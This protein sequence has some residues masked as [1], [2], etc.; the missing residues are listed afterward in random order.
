MKSAPKV[1][2]NFMQRLPPEILTKILLY[3]D[4][5]SL[6]CIGHVNKLFNLLANNNAMW[7]R[8][9]MLAF[10]KSKKWKPKNKD[11]TLKKLST[12]EIQDKPEGYWR[13]LYFRTMAGYNENKW[14]KELQAI[15][16]YTGLPN[17]T[18]W[19]LRNLH[20]TWELTVTDKLGSQGTFEQRN[21]Y[22]SES[23]V[24]VCWS[25]G[26]WPT[27]HQLS[28]LQL[29][30]VMR[31]ALQC[32]NLKKP[33]W[34]SLIVKHDI[35]DISKN[36]QIIGTDKLIKLMLLSSGIII[37]IWRDQWSIAFV[38]FSLHFN[39]LV[40]KSLLGSSLCPYATPVDRLPFDDVDPDYGL[41]G[42]TLHILL[43]NTVTQIM[44]GHFPKLFCRKDHIQDGHIQLNAINRGN[45]SQH[46]PLSGKITLPWKTDAL[47]G[48]VENC[49]MTSLTLLDEYQ[50]PFWCV[51]SPVCMVFADDNPVSYDYEGEHFLIKYQDA[52]GRLHMELVWL[53]E[54]RQFFLICL[55]VFVAV[56]KVNK[57]FG[58]DY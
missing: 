11:D 4:A 8:M 38:M 37:G 22:F 33:G 24:T 25:G 29:H 35:D 21:L 31:V 2:I 47:H 39:K 43:H 26:N 32:P 15:N 53:E 52:E 16:P 12:V 36:S 42:Y 3:L 10:G 48:T 13:R 54:Q 7:H 19:V 50:N 45:L 27:F 5:S 40:E 30:G 44:S 9:N 41:H 20:V 28:T 46:T 18:E 1:T 58:R 34:R 23:S 14:K 51:S 56:D 57:H 6:F 49:C 55:S 17:Q